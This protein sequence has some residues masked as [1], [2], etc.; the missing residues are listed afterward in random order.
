MGHL[1]S[2]EIMQRIKRVKRKNNTIS[3]THCRGI[4]PEGLLVIFI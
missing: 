3:I 2:S 1:I 4:Q